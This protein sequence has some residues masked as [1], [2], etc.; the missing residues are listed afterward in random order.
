MANKKLRKVDDYEIIS[1]IG[2]GLTSC[3]Y[4][5][6]K[7][8]KQWGIEQTVAL[9]ILKSKQQVQ[10]FAQE[11]LSLSQVDSPHCVKLYGWT[12]QDGAPVLILEH[13]NG[14]SLHELIQSALLPS[15]L[16]EEITAQIQDGLRDLK[17]YG[18]RHGDLGPKNIF[19][20]DQGVVKLLDFGFSLQKEFQAC[21]FAYLACEGWKKGVLSWESD[22][23]S[24]GLL[25][26]E[27]ETL[28]SVS[29]RQQAEARST[30]V[31]NKSSL[32]AE[33][34][35]DRDFL[36][37][38]SLGLRREHLSLLVQKIQKKKQTHFLQSTLFCREMALHR[39]M[40]VG[41]R[42]GRSLAI[43]A[44]FMILFFSN[45]L[46][47]ATAEKPGPSHSRWRLEVRSQ[48]WAEVVLYRI[49][50]KKSLLIDQQ[51]TPFSRRS[52]PPGDYQIRWSSQK[53]SGLIFVQLNKNRRILLP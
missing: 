32:L 6:I 26:I 21:T 31:L 18:L 23:F 27:M 15:D 50:N 42:W 37:L 41:S 40:D 45:S 29:T 4:K 24:L 17:R 11:V 13:L 44:S 10:T 51:Y 1:C 53:Q 30:Q 12:E 33:N 38:Q 14:I 3:V 35:K 46:H 7:K 22:L 2:E 43:C 39:S 34:P 28:E 20:T 5:A 36:P 49:K 9:K 25:K 47:P 52:L 48:Q 8:N 16:I 19:V